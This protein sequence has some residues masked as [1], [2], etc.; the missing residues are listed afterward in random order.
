MQK[1]TARAFLFLA[2]CLVLN[3][4]GTKGALYLPERQYPQDT[5]TK[6]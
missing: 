6:H 5:A 1:Y 3:S 2:I 4:C